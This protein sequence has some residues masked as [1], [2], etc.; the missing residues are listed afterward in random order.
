MRKKLHL[1]A[2]DMGEGGSESNCANS[3]IS[4]I[5]G[6]DYEL[7]IYTRKST[8]TKRTVTR[9]SDE[10]TGF[11]HVNSPLRFY[12]TFPK[13]KQRLRK[14]LKVE[15]NDMIWWLTPM[16]IKNIPAWIMNYDNVI[17]GPIGGASLVPMSSNR[18]SY[19]LRARAYNIL[20]LYWRSRIKAINH[21]VSNVKWIA[22]DRGSLNFFKS[23]NWMVIWSLDV[24]PQKYR[25]MPKNNLDKSKS[26]FVPTRDNWRKGRYNTNLLAG[27]KEYDIHS[28]LDFRHLKLN[29]LKPMVRDEYKQ[30]L[31]KFN[32][33]VL[34][35]EKD[36][37]TSTVAEGIEAG[38]LPMAYNNG[39]GY[40][41]FLEIYCP[42]LLFDKISDKY[43]NEI[44][45]KYDSYI[46]KIQEAIV[47]E[48]TKIDV[49]LNS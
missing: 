10:Y 31:N 2:Y 16:G 33:M 25:R 15:K 19:Q 27:I 22:S 39:T 3:W 36:G 4:L 14:V 18:I 45:E 38:V 48:N 20:V 12:L 46:S 43:I 21:T 8:K 37:F 47:C 1:I 23:E 9:I 35:S 28:F 17:I 7:T 5:E 11:K 34:F 30:F 13:W 32:A 26:L 24:W 40:S 44:M 49:F 6:Y 41:Y 42:E 29:K